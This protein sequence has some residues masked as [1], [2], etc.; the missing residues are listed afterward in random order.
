MNKT[1]FG[2]VYTVIDRFRMIAVILI[3]GYI[4]AIGALQIFMRYTPG[5]NPWSWV[6]E[7]MR[8]LNIWV[9][10]LAASIGVKHGKHLRMD[11]L[12]Y[13]VVPRWAVAIIRPLTR[14]VMVLSLCLLI[15]Y[16]FQRTI[17]NQRTLI[18]SLPISIAWFYA[19]IP[20][21]GVLTL[22]EYFVIFFRGED[23]PFSESDAETIPS[24]IS[25][26]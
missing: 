6:A 25:E 10:M 18:Q 12:L 2:A 4:I 19:A 15:Y 16:G 20:V 3:F 23:D 22:L 5:I 7:I 13:K 26:V 1:F 24:D 11:Y 8:Y 17:A 21:G 9:V 14:V